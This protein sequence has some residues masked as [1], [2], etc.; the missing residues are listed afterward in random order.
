[1]YTI[2][3]TTYIT[4]FSSAKKENLLWLNVVQLV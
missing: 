2:I 3:T 1:M 4:I